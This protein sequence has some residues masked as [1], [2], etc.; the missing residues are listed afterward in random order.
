MGTRKSTADTITRKLPSSGEKPLTKRAT[1]PTAKASSMYC[2]DPRLRQ[3]EEPLYEARRPEEEKLPNPLR[4]GGSGG[5]RRSASRSY[6]A[7]ISSISRSYFCLSCSYCL[8]IPFRP[9][10]ARI[11]SPATTELY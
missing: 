7:R 8:L 4:G 6:L 1:R 9:F 2:P 3:I 10:S 5:L 11:G